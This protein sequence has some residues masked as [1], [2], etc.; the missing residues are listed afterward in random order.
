MSRTEGVGGITDPLYAVP[1]PRVIHLV[2]ISPFLCLYL[3]SV[4][5]LCIIYFLRVLPVAST[6]QDTLYNFPYVSWLANV[7]T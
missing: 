3:Q 2:H 4:T 7:C 5:I 1:E 6:P